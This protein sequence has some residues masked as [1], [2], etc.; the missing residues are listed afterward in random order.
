M[1]DEKADELIGALKAINKALANI[2][3][4]LEHGLVA[5]DAD[6]AKSNFG[7]EIVT[8]LKALARKKN[9]A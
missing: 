3:A 7:E 9:T 6:I 8:Q 5:I 1:T 2:G 4:V